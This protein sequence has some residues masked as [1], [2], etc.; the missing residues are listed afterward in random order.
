M[1]TFTTTIF[2]PAIKATAQFGK[3][4]D[5]SGYRENQS[6]V[7]L[8]SVRF[9]PLGS[10]VFTDAFLIIDKSEQSLGYAVKVDTDDQNNGTKDQ[11][12]CTTSRQLSDIWSVERS[13]RCLGFKEVDADLVRQYL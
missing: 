13:L 4:S 1:S 12:Y 2:T 3:K 11:Y 9:I 8:A 5:A 7:V 10:K 6:I